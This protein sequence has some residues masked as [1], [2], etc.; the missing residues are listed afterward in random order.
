MSQS[1]SYQLYYWPSIPG[2]GEFVR[3]VF[4]AAEVAYRDVARHEGADAIQRFMQGQAE[5]FPVFAPPILVVDDDVV[6]AQT[7]NIC[8]FLARRFGLVPTDDRVVAQA[9]QLQLTLA[10]FVSEAHDTHHP[11]GVALYYEDQQ[12]EARRR[13]SLFVT[14]RMERF[15]GYLERTVERS[16]G[17]W[18]LGNTM[19]HVDLALFQILEG[20]AYAF[21][22]AWSHHRESVPR[23]VSIHDRVAEHPPIA[24][25]LRSERR[26]PFN[27]HGIFRHYP[28]LDFAH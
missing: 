1:T 2:R 11:I 20:L 17:T 5:G 10:D 7:A 12:A 13:A 23:L 8:L 26:V 14:Q 25:Y 9:L 18:L 24:A 28:E 19:T 4:E 6:L 15:L 21:P 16:K 3:L 27:E 22:T